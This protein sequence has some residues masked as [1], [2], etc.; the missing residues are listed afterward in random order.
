VPNPVFDTDE[1]WNKRMVERQ[2][3]EEHATHRLIHDSLGC[4]HCSCDAWSIA[5]P[6][7]PVRT[8][9]AQEYLD[10]RVHEAYLGHVLAKKAKKKSE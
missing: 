6:A 7:P 8:H 1:G 9:W 3:I 5:L 10:G 4:A 2:L